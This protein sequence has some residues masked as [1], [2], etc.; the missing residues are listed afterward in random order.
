M[1]PISEAYLKYNREVRRNISDKRNM[2]KC[3]HS[4]STQQHIFIRL[5]IRILKSCI[6]EFILTR[7]LL[8][9]RNVGKLLVVGHN[10]L[11]IREFI[12]ERNP[13]N[14]WNVGR[15]L[16]MAHNLIDIRKFILVRNSINVGNVGRPLFSY[17][18][19]FDI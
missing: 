6:R 2:K 5:F 18:P 17:H 13:M 19:L 10:L 7:D 15:P 9:V 4:A 3:L 14:V 11:D 1:D 12:L 16:V 8:N